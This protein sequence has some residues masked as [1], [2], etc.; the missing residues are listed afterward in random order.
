MVSVVGVVTAVTSAITGAVVSVVV[1]LSVV[2]DAEYSSS[3]STQEMI[4]RL[5]QVI[6][7]ICKIFQIMVYIRFS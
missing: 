1:V 7:I 4:L 2:P 6:R 5:K 3:S